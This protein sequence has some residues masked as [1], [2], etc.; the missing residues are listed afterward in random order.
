MNDSKREE[1]PPFKR[2]QN[3]KRKKEIQRL[4]ELKEKAHAEFCSLNNIMQEN[5]CG[6][7]IVKR[8]RLLKE[9]IGDLKRGG[10][11]KDALNRR[12]LP[13]KIEKEFIVKTK[14]FRE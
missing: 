10:T 7:R 12:R 13:F 3:A 11:V 5:D 14:H 6:Q 8:M 9:Q 2:I 1:M 4:T